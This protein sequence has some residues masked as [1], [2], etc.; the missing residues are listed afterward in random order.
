SVLI[1]VDVDAALMRYV[2][3]KGSV[4]VDGI[5]LTVN[6]CEK[7]RFYVNM[8]PHTADA[9]TLGR[10]RAGETVNIE[11]DI[12]GKYVE[13]LAAPYT[14]TAPAGSGLSRD[15]LSRHGFIK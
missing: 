10:K 12:I 2:V 5:S 13:R 3:E 6:R 1:G 7:N 9:T 14:G 8:I 15:L 4:A 11:T